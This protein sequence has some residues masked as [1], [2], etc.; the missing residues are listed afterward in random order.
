MDYLAK[1]YHLQTKIEAHVDV[2]SYQDEVEVE[3]LTC[4]A[5]IDDEVVLLDEVHELIR[6]A[7][8][9][10]AHDQWAMEADE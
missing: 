3:F 5:F 7:L 6:Q 4:Y 9:D 10:D 1:V 8:L 2:R